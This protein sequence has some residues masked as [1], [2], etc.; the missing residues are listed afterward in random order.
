[1]ENTTQDIE[2]I[3][4]QF[5]SCQ[6]TFVALGDETR[7]Y[8][9]CILLSGECGGSRVVDIAERTN[10]SRPA[11]SHH[12]QVLKNAGIVKARKEGTFIYYY[13]DPQ[14]SE[15]QK[16]IDLFSDIQRVMKNVPDRSS[17]E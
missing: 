8:L 16:I 15:I 7:L 13:L 6:R 2:R 9:L 17:G 3:K 14:D 5:Q 4:L 1:M 10:L 12:M 11:V